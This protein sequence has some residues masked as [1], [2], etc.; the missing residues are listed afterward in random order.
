MLLTLPSDHGLLY[1]LIEY[2]IGFIL[3]S[4][5]I[6]GIALMFQMDERYAFIRFLAKYT[7]PFIQPFKSIIPPIGPLNFYW[8]I[9]FF[10][11]AAVQILLLQSLPTGW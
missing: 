9:A 2:G 11:L 1:A 4:M 10:F 5:F 3:I 6:R 7:D 8:M